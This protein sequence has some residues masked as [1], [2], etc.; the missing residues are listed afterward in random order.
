MK[1]IH[2]YIDAFSSIH[3]NKQKGVVAPHKAVLLLA[4]I[5]MI[6]NERVNSPCIEL[7]D[8]LEK[9]FKETWERYVGYS[10]IFSPDITKPFFHL[11]HEPFWWLVDKKSLMAFIAAEDDKSWEPNKDKKDLPKGSYSIEAMREAF[12]YAEIDE[13]LYD[14]LWNADARASLRTTLIGK[15]LVG[16][17][18]MKYQPE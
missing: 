15:Y 3:T 8:A 18:N 5:D 1:D 6:A 9:E 16:Q 4:I 17:P 14:L 12:A 11:Q 13:E 7:T 2:Y 10:T